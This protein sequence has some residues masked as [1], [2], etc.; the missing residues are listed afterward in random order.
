MSRKHWSSAKKDLEYLPE[1]TSLPA[2]NRP[3]IEVPR[4]LEDPE[5][6]SRRDWLLV[7]SGAGLG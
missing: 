6:D 2:R 5:Q 4:C 1:P 3:E 7:V